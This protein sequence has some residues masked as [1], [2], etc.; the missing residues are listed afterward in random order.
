MFD[1][2]LE[3]L[4]SSSYEKW[5]EKGFVIVKNKENKIIKNIKNIHIHQEINIKF[6]KGE[7][8]ARVKKVK[9][10]I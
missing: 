10:D 8:G 5:L 3:V 2:R 9:E 4:F 6:F 1:Y 7:V